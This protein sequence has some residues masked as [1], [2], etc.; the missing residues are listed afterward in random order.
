MATELAELAMPHASAADRGRLRF[1]VCGSVDDGKSTLVGRLLY[2]TRQI[3]DDQ[4]VTLKRDSQRYGTTADVDF[5]LL[6]DGLEA[7]R[8]QGITIDVA[9]RYFAT[10]RRSFLVAD[11]PGHEQYTRNM[12]TGASN[13]DLAVILVDARKGLLPQTRRHLHVCALFGIGH[14][15]LAVNKIDLVDYDEKVF[16]RIAA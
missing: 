4:M 3:F 12:A 6:L 8:Q 5:A 11:A 2:E 15:V 7:E 13:V 16:G 14:I 9:Y 1:L 10:S